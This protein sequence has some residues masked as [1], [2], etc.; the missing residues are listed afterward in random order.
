MNYI[1]K[2][3]E[4]V[5]L[6]NEEGETLETLSV[7]DFAPGLFDRRSQFPVVASEK[8]LKV[9]RYAALHGHS[10]YSMLDGASHIS[11]IVEKSEYASALTD[12]G[13][14]FGALEFY[15]G[16][17]STGKKP[18]MGCEVYC[19][20]IEGEK[21]G[22]HL[23][24]LAET[25]QGYYNLLKL[26]SKAYENI[27][28]KPHIKW[29]WMREYSEGIIATSA[30]LGS[31]VNRL[32]A[33]GE[34]EKARRVIEEMIDI[35]GKDNYFIEI[36][37]HG[38]DIEEIVNPQ[39]IAFSKE[40]GLKMIATTDSHYTNEEDRDAQEIL[41]CI[42]TKTTI[43]NPN[44]LVFDGGGY[45]IHDSDEM[46]ELF[47][48]IPEVLDNTLE[49]A[50]RCN[51]EIELGKYHMP[52]F[53]IPEPFSSDGE[54]FAHLVKEGFKERFEG[55][56]EYFSEE[57]LERIDYEIGV[58]NKMGFASYFLITW[59]I[60]KFAKENGI[61]V[62]PGRG[63][64]C[65]SLV[66]YCLNITEV[67]SIKYG[68]LFERF[69][70]EDRYSMP[71]I[72]TDFDDQRREEIIEYCRGLYGESSVARIMTVTRLTARSVIKDVGKVLGYP[73]GFCTKLANSIPEEPGMTLSKAMSS[74]PEFK[75]FYEEDDAVKELV[76]YA[77]IL[78]NMP[79]TTGIH[80]CGVIIAP[81]AVDDYIPTFQTKDKETGEYVFTTQ[82]DKNENETCG[83]LKMDFLGLRTMSVVSDTLTM[84]NK[85]REKMGEEPLT[86]NSTPKTDIET[87]K[88]IANG[89][90]AGIFQLEQPGMTKFMTELFQDVQEMNQEDGEEMYERLFAGISLYRPG[91]MD[92]IPNYIKGMVDPDEIHYDLPELEPILKNTYGIIVYQEQC[93]RIVR[94]LA[95]FSRGQSDEIR[96]GMAKKIDSLL[97]AYEPSFIHGSKELNIKGAVPLGLPQRE[98]EEVWGK[99]MKFS[100]YA[101]NKSHAV[102]YAFIAAGTGY[103][104]THYLAEYLT[105][106]MNSFLKKADKVQTYIS[107][108]KRRKLSVLP[109]SINQSESKFSVQGDAIRF[110]LQGI[111][112]LKSISLEILN[113]KNENGEFKDFSSFVNRMVLRTPKFKKSH[114]EALVY[115][116]ALDEFSGT[117]KS[118]IELGEALMNFAKFN[119]QQKKEKKGLL[120]D[121]ALFN[122]DRLFS[123]YS[124]TEEEEFSKDEIWDN[125]RK[126]AGFYLSGHPMDQFVDLKD[127]DGYIEIATLESELEEYMELRKLEEYAPKK[128][129][130]IAGVV[131]ETPKLSYSK[132]GDPFLAFEIED[133]T[134]SMNILLFGEGA[135]KSRALI[136]KGKV[137]YITG[138]VKKERQSSTFF[139]FLVDDLK[140][141]NYQTSIKELVLNL[142]YSGELNNQIKKSV[143][144]FIYSLP[145]ELG[146]KGGFIKIVTPQKEHKISKK[147]DLSSQMLQQKLKQLTGLTT[148]I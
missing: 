11:D 54:Y 133:A 83:L 60:I 73:Y 22:R 44:R 121:S 37:R 79:K 42:S 118:K 114:I 33:S 57:Y 67:D 8:G 34:V 115:S 145:E 117:R 24:L 56:D 143:E 2:N 112:S 98:V 30:C 6:K 120:F 55:T 131:V 76:D 1:E 137:L 96:S 123:F 86:F 94:D 148:I 15:Q 61:L 132:K 99:M 64:A 36:Q 63:S 130:S 20:T 14:M 29:E 122:Q 21:K 31:E 138:S 72:D 124:K 93:M 125:E 46:V 48:D 69:L 87:Y 17:K 119:R 104:A 147:I 35:F 9:V 100:K 32:I 90:T 68:L 12:H 95:G 116:G 111:R 103:L 26:V 62:G 65:G 140:T 141:R 127:E 50:E 84:V 4:E 66:A 109:P 13:N 110:G 101:F 80:A 102:G 128:K 97:N 58:I 7:S 27:H 91:P 38:I 113:E 51:V 28:Y 144:D 146:P 18:I 126:Y 129:H 134:S 45:H 53:A 70:N 39:L 135:I 25:T 105:A 5:F 10:G 74:S 71:D 82:F 23:L 88:N 19:E 43:S 139:A 75:Q 85:K 108:A 49:I 78:E 77:F 81:G 142:R 40:F 107:V 3:N 106:T 92:E 136:E 47:S 41:L 89:N 16:M 52:K 59:D